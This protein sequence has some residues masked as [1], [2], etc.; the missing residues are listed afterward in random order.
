M[1]MYNLYY[2]SNQTIGLIFVNYRNV[3]ADITTELQILSIEFVQPT[4]GLRSRNYVGLRIQQED[5][6]D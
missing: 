6:E 2:F 1:K 5:Y 3:L 4:R